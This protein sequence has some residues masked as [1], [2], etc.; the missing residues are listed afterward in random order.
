MR[1]QTQVTIGSRIVDD[2][3]DQFGIVFSDGRFALVDNYTH[4]T[5]ATSRHYDKCDALRTVLRQTTDT[6]VARDRVRNK[7]Q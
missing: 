2:T 7:A 6:A 4:V 5:V 3:R 1:A